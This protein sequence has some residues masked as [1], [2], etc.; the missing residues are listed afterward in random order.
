VSSIYRLEMEETPHGRLAIVI[1]YEIY[2]HFDKGRKYPPDYADLRDA[3]E[4]PLR[5]EILAARLE[6]ARLTPGNTPRVLE[7]TGELQQMV[8]NFC[9]IKKEKK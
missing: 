7:L 3:I 5:A 8:V 6:E 4:V 9:S 2:K 1:R